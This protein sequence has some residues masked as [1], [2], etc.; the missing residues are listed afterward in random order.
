MPEGPQVYIMAQRLREV[1]RDAVLISMT[2][3]D[4]DSTPV[5]QDESEATGDDR[6]NV[7]L[8][9]YH[10]D[11]ISRS[12]V[13]RVVTQGKRAVIVLDNGQG[14][15]ITFALSGKLEYDKPEL[16]SA[17]TI[18]VM[19][20]LQPVTEEEIIVTLRDPQRLA[21]T[22]LDDAAVILATMLAIGFDPLH[23]V[24]GMREWL[25]ICMQHPGQ[26]VASFLTNQSIVAGIG[27][28][29]RSEIMHL[30]NIIP[31]LRIRDLSSEQLQLLLITIYRVLKMASRGEYQFTVYG[32]KESPEGVPVIKAEVAKGIFVWTTAKDVVSARRRP[33]AVKQV[34]TSVNRDGIAGSG[35]AQKSASPCRIPRQYR[36]RR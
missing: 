17:S 36:A 4:A 3:Y 22:L 16:I 35:S 34:R 32:R 18:S 2:L 30:A 20:F 33:Q 8:T 12:S 15:L 27:N 10:H 19:R 28:R 1:L 24:T 6:S 9:P 25:S 29:Y 5:S 14:I 21:S 7:E 31:D 11:G 13:S 23:T 26:L